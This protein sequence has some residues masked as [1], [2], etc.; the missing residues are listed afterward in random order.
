MGLRD[1]Q[2]KSDIYV[3]GNLMKTVGVNRIC[4][5]GT[6]KKIINVNPIFILAVALRKLKV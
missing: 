3:G 6:F 2:C 4:N 5:G 1:C